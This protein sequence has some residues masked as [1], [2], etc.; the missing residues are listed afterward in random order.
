MHTV[1]IDD[2][3]VYIP[4]L[5]LPVKSLAEA[6]NIEYDKLHKGL[7]LT[8]M[9]L[10]DVHEDVATMAAN[11][12]LD[13]L[14]RNKIDPSS[15]GRLYLG[16]ESSLDGAKPMASYVLDMLNRYYES[17][18][19]RK[20]GFLNCDA[21]DLTFACIGA[22]DAM[23]NALDWIRAGENRM[24]VVVASDVARYELGSGGEYTQGA[25]AVAM[26][27]CQS[28]ALLAIEPHWG[29]ATKGVHDFFKPYRH[30]KKSQMISNI[31]IEA[32]IPGPEAEKLAEKIKSR[33]TINEMLSPE[34][35]LWLHRDVPVFDGPYSNDCYRE[36]IAQAY[37]HWKDQ[38]KSQEGLSRWN[39]LI[40]HL[41]YAYQARRMFTEL[42]WN[43]M[44]KEHRAPLL[45]RNGIVYSDN[46]S[47]YSEIDGEKAFHTFLKSLSKTPEYKS[48][49]KE[50]IE[51]GERLSSQVGNIYTGSIFLALMSTLRSALLDGQEL[52]GAKFGFF[53][54]GSGS[55]S[56]VFEATVQPEWKARTERFQPE[57]RLQQRRALTF[58]AYE[59]LHLGNRKDSVRAPRESFFLQTIELEKGNRQGAR[60]YAFRPAHTEPVG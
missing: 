6:R 26:L 30:I 38:S 47:E 13:L 45:E 20:S 55:K 17:E 40:C 18:E 52:N 3:S 22:V 48:F 23:E 58:E 24:A 5:F 12:V 35:D 10:A 7:G 33:E 59:E 60:Q 57:D 50:K 54:Y 32:G 29:V 27:L 1:G 2:L 43:T 37:A 19:G 31:L 8:A 44:P 51:P 21:V 14:Q 11:A 9:A 39:R 56:K 4:G 34:D 25:G 49:V 36:R 42:F 15:V 28:P 41:P 16:T 53:A 46:N